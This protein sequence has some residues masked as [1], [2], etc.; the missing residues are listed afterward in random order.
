M[1]WSPAT[2][3]ASDVFRKASPFEHLKSSTD[4]GCE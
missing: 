2:R 1:M 3:L 4:E